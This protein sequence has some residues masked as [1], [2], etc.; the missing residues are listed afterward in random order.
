MMRYAIYLLLLL[1]S[2]VF[3]AEPVYTW[4]YRADDPDRVYLYR[5]GKQIGGWCYREKHY[6]PFDGATWGQASA[7]SPVQPPERRPPAERELLENTPLYAMGLSINAELFARVEMHGGLRAKVGTDDLT[8]ELLAKGSASVFLAER[9]K[10]AEKLKGEKFVHPVLAVI[11]VEVEDD[12]PKWQPPVGNGWLQSMPSF[13]AGRLPQ[14]WEQASPAVL[15]LFSH[16]VR[17][18]PDKDKIPV[19]GH[20]S[21]VFMALKDGKGFMKTMSFDVYL[22]KVEQ[23]E[24]SVTY[25]WKVRNVEYK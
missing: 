9:A 7:T 6:R 5:D 14:N 15:L 11:Y 18:A 1:A 20:C 2:P 13:A 25:P 10:F 23:R 8:K 24:D 16:K 12:D 19:T 3:S 22:E 4:Q 21:F 17:K